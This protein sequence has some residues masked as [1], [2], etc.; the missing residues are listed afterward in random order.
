MMCARRRR[1]AWMLLLVLS[2]ELA[3][4]CC[5]YGHESHRLCSGHDTCALCAFLRSA[6]LRAPAALCVL[7]AW[8]ALFL[9][10][11]AGIARLHLRTHR[12]LIQLKVRMND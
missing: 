8:L 4:L 12:S 6:P 11:G 1:L 10:G 9:S 7:M 2:L 3:I 5:A